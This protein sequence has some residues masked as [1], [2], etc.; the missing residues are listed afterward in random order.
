MNRVQTLSEAKII[1]QDINNMYG[2]SLNIPD[3]VLNAMMTKSSEDEIKAFLISENLI[4][5]Q[6][7]Q[8]LSDFI[9]DLKTNS[10]DV[11]IDEFERSVIS[12]NLSQVEFEK[13]NIVANSFKILND[14]K[15]NLFNNAQSAERGVLSCIW[16]YVL[17]IFAVI[18]FFVACLGPQAI[19][20]CVI[21]VVALLDQTLSTAEECA[22]YM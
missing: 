4:N 2:T 22:G 3:N 5:S 11:S 21:A 10:F 9:N 16:N 7:I 19:F 20:L 14:E 1:L 6:D 17:W 8:L 15:V 12:L 13:Y 18:A